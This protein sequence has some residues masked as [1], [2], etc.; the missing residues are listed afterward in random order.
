MEITTIVLILGVIWLARIHYQEKAANE[1]RHRAAVAHQA[2]LADLERR[3]AEATKAGDM[4]T[5]E[6]L[7]IDWAIARKLGAL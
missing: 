3:I 6:R 4:D 7:A 2:E 1:A 5:A